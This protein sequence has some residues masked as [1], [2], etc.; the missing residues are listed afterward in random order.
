VAGSPA[1][2]AGLRPE[3]L[4]LGVDGAA[5]ANV[6]DLQRLMTGDRIGRPVAVDVFRRGAVQTLRVV[7]VELPD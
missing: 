5:V 3:D 2:R 1:D 4:L 7:P 6:G